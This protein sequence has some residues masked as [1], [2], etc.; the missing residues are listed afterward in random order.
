MADDAISASKTYALAL[1]QETRLDYNSSFALRRVSDL[2]RSSLASSDIICI[3]VAP[4]SVPSLSITDELIDF[5]SEKFPDIKVLIMYVET[6]DSAQKSSSLSNINKKATKSSNIEIFELTS[7]SLSG[8][9]L[10]AA[11]L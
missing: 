5:M 1:S 8:K 9:L 10:E 3:L 4:N 2:P 6:T 7:P 11:I